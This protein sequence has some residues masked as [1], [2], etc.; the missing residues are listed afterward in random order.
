MDG[1][2]KKSKTCDPVS[3]AI[4]EVAVLKCVNRWLDENTENPPKA[5]KCSIS[6]S[7]EANI[8]TKVIVQCPCCPIAISLGIQEGKY[9]LNTNFARH[10]HRCHKDGQRTQSVSTMFAAN[11]TNSC[12]KI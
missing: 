2:V 5:I 11:R 10:F 12:G 6:I 1:A 4:H 9:A 8:M 7:K 3:V